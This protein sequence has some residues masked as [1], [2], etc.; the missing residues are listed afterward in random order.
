MIGTL[1][2]MIRNLSGVPTKQSIPPK[3]IS[4]KPDQT[5]TIA[6]LEQKKQIVLNHAEEVSKHATS[7]RN[8]NINLRKQVDGFKHVL[9]KIAQLIPALPLEEILQ[10]AHC[11]LQGNSIYEENSNLACRVNQ[12]ERKLEEAYKS[13]S[14]FQKAIEQITEERNWYEHATTVLEDWQAQAKEM[15]QT[16]GMK[17]VEFREELAATQKHSQT[18]QQE[19]EKHQN[20]LTAE[21]KTTLKV[22]NDRLKA[23]AEGFQ[24]QISDLEHDAIQMEVEL[25][26]KID[27][28]GL[29]IESLMQDI[30]VLIRRPHAK[31]EDLSKQKVAESLLNRQ[32]QIHE[33]RLQLSSH[34][35]QNQKYK[36]KLFKNKTVATAALQRENE[37]ENLTPFPPIFSS[38]SELRKSSKT[39]FAE[40]TSL[41]KK[42]RTI[43]EEN[44]TLKVALQQK[45]FRKTKFIKI[46]ISTITAIGIAALAVT[47]PFHL[48]ITLPLV[49]V[50]ATIMIAGASYAADKGPATTQQ[51]PPKDLPNTTTLFYPNHRI[52]PVDKG[53]GDALIGL[54]HFLKE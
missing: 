22:L 26:K 52:N 24:K 10:E 12:L 45:K 29:A 38:L 44:K 20:N 15:L 37:T 31:H 11:T 47:L 17:Y 14:D 40:L 34:E 6:T 19:L 4:F 48:C 3:A 8:E 32:G 50:A 13:Q 5:E 54:S 9:V 30:Q 39:T 1:N 41:R 25:H 28:G 43:Q 7:M 42:L 23:Q 21:R 2:G 46:F 51:I 33:V 53:L 16:A 18:L 36:A 49:A 27:A 35:N